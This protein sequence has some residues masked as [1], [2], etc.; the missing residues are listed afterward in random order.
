MKEL[1]KNDNLLYI[2]EEDSDSSLYLTVTC[3]GIAM[4][5]IKVRLEE[6]ERLQY[7]EQG[8][9]YLDRLALMIGRNTTEFMHR[10]IT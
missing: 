5:D 8:E 2:L 10:I 3:G 7:H 9:T 4:Y 6:D 1:L